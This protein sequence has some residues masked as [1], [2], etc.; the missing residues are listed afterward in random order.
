MMKTKD[1]YKWEL[2]GLLW[3]AYFFNQADRMVYNTV[4]PQIRAELGLSDVHAG[5]VASLFIVTYALFVPV[6]G[7]LGDVFRR[8]SIIFWSLL[9]W[10]AATILSGF[11]TVIP[12]IKLA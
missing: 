10:S 7:Y 5:L 8:K 1:S 9:F 4:L 12:K 2:I 11:S 6:A 3:L